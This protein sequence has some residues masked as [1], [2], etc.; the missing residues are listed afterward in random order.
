M[1]NQG[2]R[3]SQWQDRIRHYDTKTSR[4]CDENS[5]AHHGT[6]AISRTVKCFAAV[7]GAGIA[8]SAD[9]DDKGT[10]ES[11]GQSG[12]SRGAWREL[13]PKLRRLENDTGSRGWKK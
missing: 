3:R 11:V 8:P 9:R 10:R 5:S 13:Q 12:V 4:Q 1:Q 6:M 7:V 2:K